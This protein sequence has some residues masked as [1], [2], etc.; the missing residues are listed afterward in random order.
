VIMLVR[1]GAVTA[2]AAGPEVPAA[3]AAAG[4][5]PAGLNGHVKPRPDANYIFFGVFMTGRGKIELRNPRLEPYPELSA[6]PPSLTT[7]P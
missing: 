1:R 4:G 3:A 7:N 6:S 2:L 5:S